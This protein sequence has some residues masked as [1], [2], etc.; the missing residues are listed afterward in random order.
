VVK[1]KNII[2][3]IVNQHGESTDSEFHLNIESDS[4]A[5]IDL[6]IERHNAELTVCQYYHQRGDLMRDPEVRFRVE[7]NGEWTPISY[8]I[9]ALNEYE[10][11][12][13]G[14]E[15]HDVLGTWQKTCEHRD[16][17]TANCPHRKRVIRLGWYCVSFSVNY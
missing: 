3:S 5:V 4:D 10:Y 14:L 13:E 16:F 2:T 11:S 7:S 15:I 9:D 8:R 17:L 1:F 12:I 6:S